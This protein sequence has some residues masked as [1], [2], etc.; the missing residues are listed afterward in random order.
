MFRK[1]AFSG[2]AIEELKDSKNFVFVS[3][4]GEEIKFKYDPQNFVYFRCRAITADEPNG[5]YDYFP[6]EEIIKSYK[7]FIGV[8]LYKDHDADSVTKA[9]GKVLWAEYIPEGKYVETICCIDKRIAPQ[10]AEAVKHG[11]IDSVSMGCNVTEVECSICHNIAHNVNELCEHC[12]PKFGMKGRYYDGKLVYEINRG[13]TFTELSLVTNPADQ[14]A[15]IFEVQAKKKVTD[16]Y[17]NKEIKTFSLWEVL[18]EMKKDN[19]FLDFDI[20]RIKQEDP[21]L[22]NLIIEY[23]SFVNPYIEKVIN[24]LNNFLQKASKI[25]SKEELYKKIYP[26]NKEYILNI[27]ED[28]LKIEKNKLG[29]I[30]NL[31]LIGKI[32]LEKIKKISEKI[33]KLD[34]LSYSKFAAF[35]FFNGIDKDLSYLDIPDFF[36]RDSNVIYNFEKTQDFLNK[37]LDKVKINFKKVY[38][39]DPTDAE[40]KEFEKINGDEL[41]YVCLNSYFGSFN[42]FVLPPK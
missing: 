10:L 8:G 22:Y 21:D 34:E 16:Y 26:D 29:E 2:M 42:S 18:N 15:R 14:T 36:K 39:I 13:I 12:H 23:V 30:F 9:I 11:I 3:K 4:D 37:Y 7:T 6:E 1:I 35:C 20:N 19:D 27:L 5:N 41:N 31:L 33:N 28:N 32:Y 25:E 24:I 40:L 38:K 17:K